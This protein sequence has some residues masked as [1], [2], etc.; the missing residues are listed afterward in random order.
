[1]LLVGVVIATRDGAL[2]G[3]GDVDYRF[4][5]ESVSKPFTAALVMQEYG[6]P[7][8]IADKI[9]GG[10]HGFAVQLQNPPVA[11]A[12]PGVTRSTVQ[13]RSVHRHVTAP[14]NRKRF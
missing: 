1:M 13:R 4:A 3:V 14:A 2:Y 10:A 11:S 5:I 6:R 12:A 8:V 7:D 9:G